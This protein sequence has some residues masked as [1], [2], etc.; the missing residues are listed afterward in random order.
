[1]K[2]YC[3]A[4]FDDKKCIAGIGITIIDGQKRRMYSSWIKAK[5]INEAELFAI[6]LAG[7]LI[8]ANG[9]IYSDSQ[10]A[11]SYVKGEIKPKVRSP[12]QYINHKR[13]EF[14]AYQIRNR[15]IIPE[16]IKAHE[17]IF[18]VHS[19]G[20]RMADLLARE[21]RAKFYDRQ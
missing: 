10:T 7:I 6:H 1:M 2:A 12:E 18:Q 13:C 9:E 14:W 4:S 8:S 16:K 5:T 21:G 11:I 17:N 19:I 15:G 3:D 20:N